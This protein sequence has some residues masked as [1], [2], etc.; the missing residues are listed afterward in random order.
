M[1]DTVAGIVALAA[2]DKAV[3]Q[4]FNIGGTEEISIEGLAHRVRD[5][6]ESPSPIEYVPYEEAYE[7]GF[8]DMRRRVPDIRK[9]RTLVGY[10]PRL[11]L[12]NVIYDVAEHR[13]RQQSPLGRALIVES[14]AS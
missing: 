1:R 12:N 13:R 14:L 8:E 5:L 2:T 3:G 11:T 4:I 9:I 10:E 6:L 7:E